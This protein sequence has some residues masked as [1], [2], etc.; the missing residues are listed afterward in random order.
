MRKIAFAILSVLIQTFTFGQVQVHTQSDRSSYAIGDYI[1][2]EISLSGP[3]NGVYGFP[4]EAGISAYD[5]ISST[6]IDTQRSAQTITLTKR[7]IYSIYEAGNVYFPQV[8]IP[9]RLP[10]DTTQYAAIADSIPLQITAIEVDTTQA[11]KPIKTVLDV[12]LKSRIST[13][14]FIILHLIIIVGFIIWF[15]FIRKKE[16]HAPKQ[17]A[18]KLSLYERTLVKLHGLEEKQLWQKGQLKWYYSE[19]TDILRGY[20]EERYGMHAQE[21]TS[22]E[23]IEQLQRNRETSADASNI[24]Y[25]LQLADMA[26]FAKSQPLPD[27]NTRAFQLVHAFVEHTKEIITEEVKQA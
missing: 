21:S 24:A 7:I 4:E 12:E 18:P 9:Y 27:E 22:D 15:F 8:T 25:V 17:V 6:P 26:K 1:R 13:L 11:I 3:A 23:I 16:I 5:I 20:L 10:N 14:W 19:L 2:I